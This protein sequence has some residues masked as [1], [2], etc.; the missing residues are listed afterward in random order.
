MRVNVHS[1]FVAAARSAA[2][3]DLV[4]G[5]FIASLALSYPQC[6]PKPGFPEWPESRLFGFPHPVV[7]LPGFD[8]REFEAGDANVFLTVRRRVAVASPESAADGPIWARA[9]S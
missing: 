8:G 1:L 5:M 9:A 4:V 7:I 3:S 6:P 2:P